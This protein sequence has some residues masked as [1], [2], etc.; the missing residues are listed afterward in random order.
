MFFPLTPA[1]RSRR[2]IKPFFISLTILLFAGFTAQA[3][4]P[5]GVGSTRGLPESSGS[6]VI[7]GR[8]YFPE[9]RPPERRF[10]VSL[11]SNEDMAKSTQTDADGAFR[12]TG[13]KSGSYTVIVEGGSD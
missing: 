7:Q 13:L 2:F 10:R 1:D 11:E 6:N 4:L 5:G 9:G 8:V 12:F 3:Q